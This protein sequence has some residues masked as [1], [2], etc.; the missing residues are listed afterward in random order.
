MEP[1]IDTRE[2]ASTDDGTAH[3]SPY[4]PFMALRFVII[5]SPYLTGVSLENSQTPQLTGESPRPRIV[6]G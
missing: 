5:R 1:H 3:F 2:Y 6:V 4:W